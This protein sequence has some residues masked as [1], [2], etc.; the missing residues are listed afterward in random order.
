MI[1]NAVAIRGSIVADG[2]MNERRPP[3][4]IYKL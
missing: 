3:G 2:E 1:G 4:G